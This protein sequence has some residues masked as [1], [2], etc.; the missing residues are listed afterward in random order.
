MSA[1]DVDPYRLRA[2]QDAA[3]TFADEV[4]RQYQVGLVS[5]SGQARRN[6][7]SG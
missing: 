1:T 4:P 5:F 7:A 6:Q 2:A 3:L